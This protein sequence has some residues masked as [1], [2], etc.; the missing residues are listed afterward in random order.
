M[1]TKID[2]NRKPAEPVAARPTLLYDRLLSPA[3]TIVACYLI[4]LAGLIGAFS[5]RVP[6]WWELMLSHGLAVYLIFVLARRPG[7]AAD[8]NGAGQMAGDSAKPLVYFIRFWYPLLLIPFTYKE[9]GYLIPRLRSH[10]VDGRL[11]A[12]D[13]RIFGTDPVLWLDRLASPPLTLLLQLSYLTY[14]LFP[15]VMAVILWRRRQYARFHFLAFVVALGFYASY[16]GYIAVPAI[17]PRFFLPPQAGQFQ[18]VAVQ[19][20]R[21]TLDRAEG[22]TRDCFPSGHTELTMLVLYCAWR[23]ERRAFWIMLPAACTLVLSTVYLK[24]HYVIDVFA[25]AVL[26]VAIMAL[27]NWLY[28]ALGGDRSALTHSRADVQ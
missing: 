9:L 23:F 25:G 15:V 22:I 20:I 28:A 8:A 4:L 5:V 12:I 11:A 16:I 27:A 26:A 24:Y 18:N 2:D 3:D 1:Q 13:F 21:R 6:L 19:F 7:L 14:Y 10:D 17:G